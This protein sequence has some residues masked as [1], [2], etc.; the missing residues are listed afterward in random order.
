MRAGTKSLLFGEHQFLIHPLYVALAWRSMFGF[1]RDLRLWLCFLVHDWGYWGKE[2]MDGESGRK[3]PWPGAVLAHRL[4]D[5]GPGISYA[6]MDFC[7]YHSRYIA[8]KG[9]IFERPVSRLALADK[10]SFVMMPWWVYLPLAWLSGSLREY[11]DNGRGM[12]EPTVGYREWHRAL[13]SKTLEWVV[14]TLQRPAASDY[15]EG[16]YWSWKKKG[17]DGSMASD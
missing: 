3:H 6:W 1:P 14:C 11:M 8:E 7:L 10:M 9:M 5:R 16:R 15:G 12:G 2:D 4:L 17:S 13:C